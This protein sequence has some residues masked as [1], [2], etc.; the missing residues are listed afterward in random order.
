MATHSNDLTTQSL[1][2]TATTDTPTHIS[3]SLNCISTQHKQAN[4]LYKQGPAQ[5]QEQKAAPTIQSHFLSTCGSITRGN[6]L[7][8]IQPDQ[9][10]N[11]ELGTKHADITPIKPQAALG[12]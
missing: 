5:Q 10:K 2:K 9:E 8:I 11:E 7:T 12:M 4:D 3:H 1:A 6:M